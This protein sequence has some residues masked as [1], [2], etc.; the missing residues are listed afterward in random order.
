MIGKLM[1][2]LFGRFVSTKPKPIAVYVSK[3]PHLMYPGDALEGRAQDGSKIVIRRLETDETPNV[4]G[5]IV[6]DTFAKPRKR[7]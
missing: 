7:S 1:D 6:V 4:A 5:S 3:N 2:K